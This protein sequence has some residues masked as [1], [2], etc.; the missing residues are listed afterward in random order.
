[1]FELEPFRR[2]STK[3][4]RNSVVS[5][6]RAAGARE[7]P[8]VPTA[9]AALRKTPR[10]VRPAQWRCSAQPREGAAERGAPSLA[11]IAKLRA[12]RFAVVHLL[13]QPSQSSGRLP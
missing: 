11:P 5:F 13:L 9:E 1:M 10:R 3:M 6:P 8:T 7:A 12:A 2:S 4:H